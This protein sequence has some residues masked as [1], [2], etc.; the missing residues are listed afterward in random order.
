M[1][2]S[3]QDPTADQASQVCLNSHVLDNYIDLST[4]RIPLLPQRY[5]WMSTLVSYH[6]IPVVLTSNFNSLLDA[7]ASSVPVRLLPY[8]LVPGMKINSLVYHKAVAVVTKQHAACSPASATDIV[9]LPATQA[10]SSKSKKKTLISKF[11]LS[12]SFSY[13]KVLSLCFSR[14]VDAVYSGTGQGPYCTHTKR[15][16][17]FCYGRSCP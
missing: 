15:R 14:P 4:S 17:K 12:F 5:L 16:C 3:A 13:F 1:S 10:S 6:S 8:S 2:P 9:N 7:R 11:L